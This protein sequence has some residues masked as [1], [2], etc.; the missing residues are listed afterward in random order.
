MRH[1]KVTTLSLLSIATFLVFTALAFTGWSTQA[2][3][4]KCTNI[5]SRLHYTSSSSATKTESG[6]SCTFSVDGADAS[7]QQQNRTASSDLR[8]F[9]SC[10]RILRAGRHQ[11]FIARM[12]VPAMV[13]QTLRD[14]Q[15]V[16]N[17]RLPRFPGFDRSVCLRLPQ[18]MRPTDDSDLTNVH[19]EL[20]SSTRGFKQCIS[21][22]AAGRGSPQG[23]SGDPCSV[24]R[25]GMLEMN[26]RSSFGRHTVKLPARMV[27]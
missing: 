16:V 23:R 26:F 25:D 13:A 10:V 19:R 24:G 14:N 4:L 9:G 2:A 18:S 27:R 5:D 1:E 3:E 17:G 20:R 15:V 21:S 7:S 6:S 8:I 12:V 22:W 11:D